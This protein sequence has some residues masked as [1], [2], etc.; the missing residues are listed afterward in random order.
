MGGCARRDRACGGGQEGEGRAGC[1]SV[2]RQKCIMSHGPNTAF[3]GSRFGVLRGT[4]SL[5]RTWGTLPCAV[6]SSAHQLRLEGRSLSHTLPMVEI[7]SPQRYQVLIPRSVNITQ[8]EKR[9]LADVI[10][11]SMFTWA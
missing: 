3:R 7:M 6:P 1:P 5:S 9:V 2:S 8:L 10:E 4:T 11:L